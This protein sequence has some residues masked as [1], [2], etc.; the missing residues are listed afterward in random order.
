MQLEDQMDEK[1]RSDVDKK[2][3][4]LTE[5]PDIDLHLRIQEHRIEGYAWCNGLRYHLLGVRDEEPDGDTAP[6]A[7]SSEP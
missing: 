2:T 7:K 5:H 3:E 4:D 1:L 6:L